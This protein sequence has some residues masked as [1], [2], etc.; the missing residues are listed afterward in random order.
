VHHHIYCSKNLQYIFDNP[1]DHCSPNSI[2][3][4]TALTTT[5]YDWISVQPFAGTT[6][7]Q[8][9]DVIS[10]FMAL[11]PNAKFVLHA[12]WT[13]EATFAD[14]YT[15]GNPDDMARPSPEYLTALRDELLLVDPTRKIRQ[16]RSNDYLYRVYQDIQDG[17]APFDSFSEMYRDSIHMHAQTGQYLMHNALRQAIDQPTSDEGFDVDPEAQAYFDD[18]LLEF[19]PVPEPGSAIALIA[20]GFAVMARRR[21]HVSLD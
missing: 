5:Q 19:A 14:D 15:A 10:V 13:A 9:V 4:T 7:Q 8:D 11:Q 17:V 21:R 12:G 2:P 3:W 16:T 18:L 20:C 6:L 1:N